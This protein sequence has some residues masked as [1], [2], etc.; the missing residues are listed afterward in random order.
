MSLL[1]W[2]LPLTPASVELLIRYRLRDGS[3]GC[4]LLLLVLRLDSNSARYIT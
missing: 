4:L 1:C 3:H 2:L